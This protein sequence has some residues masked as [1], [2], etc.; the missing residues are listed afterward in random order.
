MKPVRSVVAGIA[1]V[2]M[3]LVLLGS[4]PQADAHNITRILA[5]HPEY[6]TFNHY[7]T[8]THLAVE[9]NRR[10]TITVLAVD[11]SAMSDLLAKHLSLGTIKNVLSLHILVDYFGA[12]K[13]HQLTDRT[14]STS[15]LFQASG[16]APGTAGY[17]NITDLKGG[18]VAFGSTET[19]DLNAMFVKSVDERP[20]NISVLQISQVLT[21]PEAEAPTAAPSD[22]NLTAILT[23]QGCKAF[24]DLIT[25]SGAGHTFQE[26]ID[27]GL[28]VFCPP[29]SVVNAFMPKYKNLTAAQKAS[30]ILYHGVPVY[31]SLQGMKSSNGVMNT[32]ATDGANKYD[33]TI[34]NDGE[35]VTLKTKVTTA[36]ITGTVIDQDPLIVFKVDKVLQP[37]ELFKASEAEEAEA[38]AP[39]ATKKKKKS[40][41]DSDA[42]AD[43]PDAYSPDGEPSDLTEE[44]KDG[45][46]GLVAGGRLLAGVVLSLCL[47]VAML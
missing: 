29:D 46:A 24:A 33:F 9:I 47:S 10:L 25:S 45:A 38:P 27:G 31:Q 23:K 44:D 16:A 34:Q 6:S 2:L 39:K 5:K 32:L 35:E 37:R 12:K 26:N 36:T 28:T 4:S 18:K 19:G 43:S 22:L 20:Y 40:T 42:E 3:A 30:L 14:T 8:L 7:L 13:L 11:N 21:S 1:A 17:V 41:D 15:T